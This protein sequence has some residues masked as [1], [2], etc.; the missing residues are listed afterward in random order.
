M[1]LSIFSIVDCWELLL[2]ESFIFIRAWNCLVKLAFLQFNLQLFWNNICHWCFWRRMVHCRIIN[3]SKHIVSWLLPLRL[4]KFFK[5]LLLL[6]LWMRVHVSAQVGWMPE[7]HRRRINV[8]GVRHRELWNSPRILIQELM[9]HTSRRTI[10][11]CHE[12]TILLWISNLCVQLLRCEG[13]EH[14]S[15][16]FIAI[17]SRLAYLR[18]PG[19]SDICDLRSHTNI[20]EL[21]VI[22]RVI[23]FVVPM[24]RLWYWR[25]NSLSVMI[26]WNS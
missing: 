24:M 10:L 6:W 2:F 7:D 20:S 25:H 21:R 3:A 9:M 16:S 15:T 11:G 18:A 5:I 22:Y 1:F 4:Y 12:S 19:M 23:Q 13:R 14:I 17:I 26:H 8:W